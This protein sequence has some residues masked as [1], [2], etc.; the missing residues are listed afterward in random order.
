M[1]HALFL[2]R[3]HERKWIIRHNFVILLIKS[4]NNAIWERSC[5]IIIIFAHA[6]DTQ[7]I[8]NGI[9]GTTAPLVPLIRV[10]LHSLGLGVSVSPL[11]ALVSVE[12]H[13]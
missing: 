8:H 1:W 2:E 3:A 10:E 7:H 4:T 6:R 11:V 13:S 5:I 9:G 12:F